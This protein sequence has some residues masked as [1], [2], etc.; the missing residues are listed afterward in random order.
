M[1]F[2][3]IR[4]IPD[5]PTGWLWFPAFEI[6]VKHFIEKYLPETDPKLVVDDIRQRFLTQPKLTSFWLALDK[7]SRPIAHMVAWI[8]LNYGKPHVF[9]YQAEADD[10]VKITEIVKL[11][12]EGMDEWAKELNNTIPEGQARIDRVEMATWRDAE[13]WERYLKM[14]G[15]TSVKVR[16]VIQFDLNV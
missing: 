15:R 4:L 8:G 9:V 10:K 2:S 12:I 1:D 3:A 5:E 14:L 7:D 6:R 13:V 11:V 16:S